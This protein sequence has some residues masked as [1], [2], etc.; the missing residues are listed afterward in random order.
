MALRIETEGHYA[1]SGQK[2]GG[3]NHAVTENSQ[4]QSNQAFDPIWM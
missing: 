1:S 2:L 3:A 4:V